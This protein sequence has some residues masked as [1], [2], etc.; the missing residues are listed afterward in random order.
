MLD[1]VRILDLSR[2]MAG[3]FC[4][5]MLADVG[6][7]V[8]KIEMPE[9]GDDARHLGHMEQGISTYFLMLN[10]GKKSLTLN[11]KSDDGIDILKRL[12]AECDVLVENFR[13][14]VME[15]LG[16]GF[17]AVKSLNPAMVYASI[18]GFGQQS[19]L[20]DRPAYD[21]VIQAMSGLMSITGTPDGPPTAVG[22]SVAD[23]CSG[24]FTAWGIM[25]ALHN[26]EK[27]GEGCQIDTSMLDSL[28][29]MSLTGLSQLLY[30]GTNPKRV[31]NRHPATYPVD[32]FECKDGYVTM[33][34]TTNKIFARLMEGIGRAELGEDPKFVDNGSRNR[35]ERELKG[36]IEDWTRQYSS[37]DV[38]KK[39]DKFGVPIAPLWT[40]KQVAES[41]HIAARGMTVM[42]SHPVLGQ[43]P[44]VPQPLQFTGQKSRISGPPPELGEHTED[45]LAD[46]LGLSPDE[47]AE[48]RRDRV[49]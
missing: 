14:G 43:I 34:V 9:R 37:D 2:V 20:A 42:E 18:S 47:I 44:L 15:K 6:A 7:E 26:R 38:V 10:R 30:G 41:D 11:L 35:H 8:I 40:L 21:L 29:A 17:E 45:V 36:I 16:L 46:L 12:I 23:V 5:S 3:P 24:M 39:L 4:T 28:Y 19:P 27:T 49:I 31:G 22:E 32:S 13:P 33:V 1:G 48:L 25:V